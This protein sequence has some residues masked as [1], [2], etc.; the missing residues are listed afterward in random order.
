MA[1]TITGNKPIDL[2]P[3]TVDK[4]N[5]PFDAITSLKEVM[6]HPIFTQLSPTHPVKISNQNQSI[7]DDDVVQLIL[8]TCGENIDPVAEDTAKELYH[9][10]LITYPANTTLP[11]KSIFAVQAG[12]AANLPEPNPMVIY[13]PAQDIIPITKKFL[14]GNTD[15]N[16]LFATYAYY[17]NPNTLGFYFAT[18]SAFEDFKDFVRNTTAQMASVLPT[19]TQTLLGEF[20]KLTLNDLTESLLLRN[21]DSEELD[22]FTFARVIINL[23]MSYQNQVTTSEFGIMPFDLEELILPKSIVFVNL[24]RHSR[25]PSSK[26]ADEWKTINT[27]IVNKIPM[28]SINQLTKLTAW[29]RTMKHAASMAQAATAMSNQRAQAVRSI[30][31]PFA[32]KAPR[33]IDITKIIMKIMKKMAFVNKSM[34]SYKQVKSTFARPNRRNPDDFNKT[35]KIVSTKY[36]PDIHL[37]IDTSGSISEENYQEAVKA[38]IAMAKKLNVSLYFNSFSHVL[39]QPAKL[40]TK[41]KSTKAIYREFQ[42]IPKVSGGTEYTLVWDYIM[43]DKKRQRE[44]SILMTDFEYYAPNRHIDHPKN[45]YYIPC[46]KMDYDTIKYYAEKFVK[47]MQGN[48]PDIRNHILF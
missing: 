9:Q 30:N 7:N 12:T 48:V 32:K 42:K 21:D 2:V 31:M 36:K 38:C 13:T 19:R 5:Q 26:I 14:A 6:V 3:T 24:E 1:I 23:L 35:G 28:V 17:A 39:S 22:P 8:A 29:Q 16:T 18:A 44:I 45:L 47:S 4:V 33:T 34:N 43:R 25:A 10:C 41:D 27:S 15:Y 37:Y 46:S 40:H 11:F 20:D